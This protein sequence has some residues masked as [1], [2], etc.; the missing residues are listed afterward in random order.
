MA[1]V[2]KWYNQEIK[3]DTDSTFFEIDKNAIVGMIYKI[4]NMKLTAK[5]SKENKYFELD[6][7]YND[8]RKS[9]RCIA[10][11]AFDNALKS[12]LAIKVKRQIDADDVEKTYPIN[13]GS[14]EI[15]DII[16]SEP[17]THWEFFTSDNFPTVVMKYDSVAF[18]TYLSKNIFVIFGD[19]CSLLK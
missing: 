10:P 4:K 7:T 5:H 8:G 9:A 16:A 14:I 13:L 18:E 2:E 17:P 15:Q 6:I 12:F 19:G 1:N 3:L 11:K